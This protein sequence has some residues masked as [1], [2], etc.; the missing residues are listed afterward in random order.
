MGKPRFSCFRP[1]P[2]EC[3]KLCLGYGCVLR[4]DHDFIEISEE[5]NIQDGS[6]LHVEPGHPCI[7]GK[8]ITLGHRVT[9]HASVI[10]D[11]AMI[12]IGATVLSR[13]IIGEGA[14]IAVGALVLEGTQVP[15]G[16]LW[17]GIPARQIKELTPQQRERM[18][19]TY[20]HYVNLGAMYLRRFGRKHI[21]ALQSDVEMR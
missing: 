14:L 12:G 16:T 21:D 18:A 4:G 3:T 5:T 2:A 9:V 1:H 15:P 6:I 11:Y 17:A 20:R 10:E 19:S 7:L 8:G 13:C